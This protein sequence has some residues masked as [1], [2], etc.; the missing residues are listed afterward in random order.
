MK[1]STK[2]IWIVSVAI[3]VIAAAVAA[4]YFVTKF[5]KKKNQEECFDSLDFEDICDGDCENCDIDCE[6]RDAEPAAA[7]AN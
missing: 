4:A 1:K 5:M 3:A 2:I 7:F 6:V